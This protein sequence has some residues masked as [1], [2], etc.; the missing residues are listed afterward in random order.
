MKSISK[1]SEILVY[2]RETYSA[3]LESESVKNKQTNKQTSISKNIWFLQQ[4]KVLKKKNVNGSDFL[5]PA[6]YTPLRPAEVNW[7]LGFTM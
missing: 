6:L 5:S 3:C 1:F 2:F 7:N 4:A